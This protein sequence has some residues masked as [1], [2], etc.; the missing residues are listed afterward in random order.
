M[1]DNQFI[2]FS[3]AYCSPEMC[4]EFGKIPPSFLPVSN[5][6]LFEM[7]IQFAKKYSSNIILTVPSSYSI[8]SYDL[9]ILDKNNVRVVFVPD[10]LILLQAVYFTLELLNNN[11]STYILFG[12]TYIEYEQ[13]IDFDSI[14]Y[15]ESYEYYNWSEVI[16]NNDKSVKLNRKLEG[17]SS[18]R[19]VACGLYALKDLSLFRK[20]MPTVKTFDQLVEV[21]S[22]YNNLSLFKPMSWLDFGHLN[23]Y[24]KSKKDLLVTRSFNNIECDGYVLTKSSSNVNKLKAEANWYLNLPPTLKCFSP[25]LVSEENSLKGNKYNYSIEYLYLSNLAELY[26]FAELPSFFWEQVFE[27]CS[28]FLQ[29]AKDYYDNNLSLERLSPHEW[30]DQVIFEKTNQRLL[31][32]AAESQFDIN[33][34]VRVNTENFPSLQSLTDRLLSLVRKSDD[35]DMSFVHGDF[36]FGNI[37]F[38]NT[39]KRIKLIDPRGMLNS[40]KN[41]VYGDIRY[42]LAKLTHSVIGRYDEI[43]ADRG[44]F[45][46]N[47]NYDFMLTFSDG[48]LHQGIVDSFIDRNF[49][50]YKV[51]SQENY[52]MTCLLFISLLPLHNEDR[53]RQM[54]FVANIY[55]IY[56]TYIKD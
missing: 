18:A 25:Q 24:Y 6:R 50:G 3:G 32:F 35:G 55:R 21:Y 26:L 7:Q 29:L 34:A 49:L 48:V 12:D 46:I 47:N 19:N 53:E 22:T 20:L 43:I 5:G 31:Q 28:K 33:R 45:I 27:S 2:I 54:K 51:N 42:E 8:N 23:T 36:F 44:N 39:A 13:I 15:D 30:Y 41:S 9:E 56:S 38:D 14:A 37:L 4:A 1:I 10:S 40:E 17:S 16:V 52:A 11:L